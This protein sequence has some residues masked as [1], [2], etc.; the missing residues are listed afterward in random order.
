MLPAVDRR[1]A[2]RNQGIGTW[3][4]AYAAHEDATSYLASTLNLVVRVGDMVVAGRGATLRF[5]PPRWNSGISRS[6]TLDRD[7]LVEVIQVHDQSDPPMIVC[8]H[9]DGWWEVPAHQ[10][11]GY[12]GRALKVDEGFDQ[13]WKGFNSPI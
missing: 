2:T 7:A 12:S 4:D 6:I 1:I 5:L 10:V 13:E 9:G 8:R 3:L 11:K